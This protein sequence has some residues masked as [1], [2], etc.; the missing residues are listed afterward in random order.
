MIY[1]Y[2]KINPHIFH[3]G[4][5]YYWMFENY[6][7]Q[8]YID[9]GFYYLLRSI[10][11]DKRVDSSTYNKSPA[12]LTAA[13]RNENLY[14]GYYLTCTYIKRLENL[15][16]EYQTEFGSTLDYKKLREKFLENI[17][18]IVENEKIFFVSS[19]IRIAHFIEKNH[20]ILGKDEF[21]ST[22][23][24][25]YIFNLGLL[26]ENMLSKYYSQS[27][28]SKKIRAFISDPQFSWNNR[29]TIK[30]LDTAYFQWEQDDSKFKERFEK[31]IELDFHLYTA[32]DISLQGKYLVFLRLMRNLAGH[33]LIRLK[34]ISENSE[35]IFENII[36]AFF[37]L[38]D[39]LY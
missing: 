27:K 14:H 25:N 2:E 29:A 11:E 22:R 30:D 23:I 15:L 24:L 26:L 8:D 37:I 33:S 5:V 10:E 6:I 17:S 1:N 34:I 20:S 13:L 36:K 21:L 9:I 18:P 19:F 28:F 7:F 4:T 35:K 3:K 32:S 31:L 16:T 39:N 38:I 12:Y